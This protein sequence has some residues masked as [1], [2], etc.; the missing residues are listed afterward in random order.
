MGTKNLCFER[1]ETRLHDLLMEESD[2]GTEKVKEG[3]IGVTSIIGEMK[4]NHKSMAAR[5]DK[6][7]GELAVEK[8]SIRSLIKQMRIL[9]DKVLIGK[10]I[11][12]YAESENQGGGLQPGEKKG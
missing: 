8:E 11:R 12:I 4:F 10:E 1:D 5:I 2:I 6:L 9:Q 7:E 3:L